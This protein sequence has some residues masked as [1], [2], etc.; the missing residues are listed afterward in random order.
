MKI[1]RLSLQQLPEA[2]DLVTA[3]ETILKDVYEY[4]KAHNTDRCYEGIL[5]ERTGEKLR[6]L[7]PDLCKKYEI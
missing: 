6:K 5:S 2:K 1:R 4:D 3:I 7:L